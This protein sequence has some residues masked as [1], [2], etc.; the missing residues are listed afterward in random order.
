MPKKLGRLSR[1][2]LSLVAAFFV[3]SVLAFTGATL[4]AQAAPA[5]ENL[6]A[7]AQFSSVSTLVATAKADPAKKKER[8]QKVIDKLQARIDPLQKR[9]DTLKDRLSKATTDK[10][11]EHLKTA[12]E[13]VEKHIALIKQRIED[14]KKKL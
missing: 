12:I 7:P 10:E 14:L 1:I 6:S 5:T 2:G 9:D 11:K 4:T 8:I 3:F 13:K